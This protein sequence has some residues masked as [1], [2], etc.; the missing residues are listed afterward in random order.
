M[1]KMRKLPRSKKYRVY[2][3][4]RVIAKRTTRS[5]AQG[6]MGLIQGLKHGTIRR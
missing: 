3:G 1:L 6:Q 5:K 2:D 4:K